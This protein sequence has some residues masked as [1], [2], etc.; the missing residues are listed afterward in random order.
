MNIEGYLLLLLIFVGL[1]WLGYKIN[2]PID[3][4]HPII[5]EPNQLLANVRGEEE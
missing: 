5:P 1:Y 2:R 3:E 4:G